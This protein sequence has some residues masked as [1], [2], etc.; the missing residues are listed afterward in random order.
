MASRT[1]AILL[2]LVALAS[3]VKY[4]HKKNSLVSDPPF[5]FMYIRQDGVCSGYQVMCGDISSTPVDS[6]VYSFPD[7]CG[8]DKAL[9]NF[10]DKDFPVR[11][12]AAGK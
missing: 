7:N 3:A 12:A 5:C 9:S 8:S 4:V 11:A 1:V 6:N 10:A 2:L